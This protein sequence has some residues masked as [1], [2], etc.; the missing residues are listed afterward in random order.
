MGAPTE[1]YVRPVNGDDTDDGLSHATAFKTTQFALDNIT[2]GTSGD[3]ININDEGDEVLT[4]ALNTTTYGTPTAAK[5][6]FRHQPCC[7]P[8]TWRSPSRT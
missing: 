1:Y 5:P 8:T 2:Q 3:R 7:P 6:R 4:A